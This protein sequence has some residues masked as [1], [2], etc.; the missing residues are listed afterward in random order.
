F[1]VAAG[2]GKVIS[3]AS[4]R[5]IPGSGTPTDTETI[6]AGGK[7]IASLVVSGF[8]TKTITFK[9]G[10]SSL[11]QSETVNLTTG[12]GTTSWATFTKKFSDGPAPGPVPKPSPLASLALLGVGLSALGLTERRRRRKP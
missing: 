4:L 9:T 5:F 12:S 6:T 11:M 8:G 1:D 7:T 10:V 2:A 3:D